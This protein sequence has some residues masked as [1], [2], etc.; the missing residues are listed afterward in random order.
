MTYTAAKAARRRVLEPAE[1][2]GAGAWFPAA[3]EEGA[4]GEEVVVVDIDCAKFLRR[5]SYAQPRLLRIA[6]TGKQIHPERITKKINKPSTI[7]RA[8]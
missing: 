8:V 5:A 7:R 3:S 1:A 4:V 2:W 6:G